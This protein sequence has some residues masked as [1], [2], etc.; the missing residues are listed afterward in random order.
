MSTN[1][2]DNINN[3]NQDNNSILKNNSFDVNSENNN[4]NN[5]T[6]DNTKKK[7]GRPK[8]I[9]TDADWINVEKLAMM[10]C[11]IKEIAAFLDVHP[12]TLVK[13]ETFSSVYEKG[14]EKGKMSIR[15]HQLKL[16]ERGNAAIAIWLGKQYLN[17]SDKVEN[18]IATDTQNVSINVNFGKE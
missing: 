1:N 17:Q 15:R 12:D 10:M 2:N 7:M 9:F 16:L 14:F 6:Q 18:K 4:T 13:E 11:S 5:N 8:H 3:N